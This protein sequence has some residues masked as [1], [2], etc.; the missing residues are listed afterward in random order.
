MERKKDLPKVEIEAKEGMV[1]VN[2]EDPP[3][4]VMV[5]TPAEALIFASNLHHVAESIIDKKTK[6]Q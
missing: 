4:W 2:I 3:K 6:N 5:M 1:V